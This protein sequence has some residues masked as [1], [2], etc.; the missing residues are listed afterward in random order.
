MRTTEQVRVK[1]DRASYGIKA[2]DVVTATVIRSPLIAACFGHADAVIE[3]RPGLY[4]SL[5][6]IGFDWEVVR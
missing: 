1:R 5:G 3:P 2:G 6:N 4:V